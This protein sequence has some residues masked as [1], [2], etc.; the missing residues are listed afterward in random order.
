MQ[1]KKL[2][3]S[4]QILI[5]LI[6]GIVVGLLLQKNPEIAT[7]YIRPLG[8]VFLNAIK[9]IIVLLFYVSDF[10]LGRVLFRR[11]ENPCSK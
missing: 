7:K 2:N 8:T 11:G 4:L 5:G 1:K 6:L 3:L 9:M 10:F